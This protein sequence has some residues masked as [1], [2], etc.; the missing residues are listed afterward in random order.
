MGLRGLWDCCDYRDCRIA[1]ITGMDCPAEGS[2]MLAV[3]I[4]VPASDSFVAVAVPPVPVA[5]SPVPA[6]DSFVP[7]A[8]PSVPAGGL[9]V[10][11]AVPPVP[12]AVSPIP[13]VAPMAFYHAGAKSRPLIKSGPLCLTHPHPMAGFFGHF[14]INR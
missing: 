9:F 6:G 7:V 2:F 4:P 11:V 1:V 12:V 8:V 14:K 10:P 3:V 13:V 5:V